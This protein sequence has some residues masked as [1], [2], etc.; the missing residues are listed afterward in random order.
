M[1]NKMVKKYLYKGILFSYKM[2]LST[3]KWYDTDESWKHY[4]K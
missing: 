3:D 1:D 2:K 4:A